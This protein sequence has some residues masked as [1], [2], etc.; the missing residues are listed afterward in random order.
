MTYSKAVGRQEDESLGLKVQV[1]S[2]EHR[3]A[4]L[5]EAVTRLEGLADLL[6]NKCTDLTLVESLEQ[7]LGEVRAVLQGTA[8]GPPRAGG[9]G[10]AV[11]GQGRRFSQVGGPERGCGCI[12]AICRRCQFCR[13]SW[14]S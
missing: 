1:E 2:G 4:V 14:G 10:Q 11:G 8:G 9:Q 12:V 5:G 3:M 6:R 7:G 13:R